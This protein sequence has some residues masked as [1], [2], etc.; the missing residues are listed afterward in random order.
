M[1]SSER[2]GS[3][4]IAGASGFIGRRLVCHLRRTG[5]QVGTARL[6]PGQSTAR[7]EAGD[8]VFL[9]AGLAHSRR[10]GLS[11]LMAANCGLALDVYQRASEAGAAGFVFLST[12]KVLGERSERPLSVDAP[13]RPVGPY[14]GSKAAAE[15]RLL[16]AYRR[17]K[18]PLAIVR[19][20]LVYGA[21][22]KANFRTLLGALT[23]GLPLPVADAEGL[24]SFV[25]VGNLADALGTVGAKLH[26]GATIWHV[27]D[28]QDMDVATLCRAIA[29]KM[30]R[31]ARLLHLPAALLDI[32]RRGRGASIFEPLRLDGSA[33]REGLGWAPPQSRDAALDET[34]RWWATRR[35]APR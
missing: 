30:E 18:L 2:P 21:G 27:A 5:W 19:S 9:A 34:V 25:S 8:V 28:G 32:A 1:T 17:R 20:P 23:L 16:A 12:A 22:V 26:A 15:E 33:L 6:R 7:P 24:R 35:A 4:W 3:A 11:A 31:D 29:A 10:H 14:A 13:R